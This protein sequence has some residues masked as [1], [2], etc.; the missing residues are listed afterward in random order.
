MH[1]D[2]FA[3]LAEAWGSD[4]SASSHGKKPLGRKA[5]RSAAAKF[6]DGE[7]A[8]D[9]DSIMDMYNPMTEDDAVD[10]S[11]ARV[12]D[13]PDS[14]CGR[15]ASYAP[16]PAD[17]APKSD[18][19]PKTATRPRGSRPADASSDAASDSGDEP[20]APPRT[21]GA[22]ASRGVTGVLNP[23]APQDLETMQ[24]PTVDQD[25]VAELALYV[26]SGLLLI[27]VME[28]FV[29]IGIRVRGYA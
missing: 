16:Y 20:H 12:L 17:R 10:A 27:L 25:H 28:Q 29:Q 19:T 1:F 22:P 14:S 3:T 23:K 7:V 15:F 8:Y 5:A 21:P 13:A 24:N 4:Y 18:R 9:V 6:C 26:V 11:S 2:N